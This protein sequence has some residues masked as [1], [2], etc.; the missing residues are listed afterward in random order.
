MTSR[1]SLLALAGLLA[2]CPVTE[3]P[4]DPGQP[5]PDP[6]PTCDDD[7]DGFEA[8]SCGGEDCDDLDPTIHPAAID[9]FGDG[10]DQDCDAADLRLDEVAVP[11][12]TDPHDWR[13]SPDLRQLG[14]AMTI[15]S[16]ATAGHTLN[17]EGGFG[18]P[19][20]SQDR[21]VYGD[22]PPVST[23]P[24]RLWASQGPVDV[25]ATSEAGGSTLEVYAATGVIAVLEGPQG[26]YAGVDGWVGD[27]DVA[28][29]VACGNGELRYLALDLTGEAVLDDVRAVSPADT[30]AVL[31]PAGQ[32]MVLETVSTGAPL[33]RWKIGEDGFTDYLRLA[34]EVA[35]SAFVSASDEGGA[36]FAFVEGERVTAIS[37]SGVAHS[38][39]D[40]QA[41][42]AIGLDVDAQGDAA[43]VWADAA[44]EVYAAAGGFPGDLVSTRIDVEVWPEQVGVG[45]TPGEV[46]VSIW[47]GEDLLLARGVR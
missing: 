11:P 45:L 34:E 35:P 19:L 40:G 30:C 22:L 12:N 14:G 27:D 3:P 26:G 41:I 32:V 28:H 36:L 47:D 16:G 1:L 38:L 46:D 23:R 43:L 42:H 20:T 21:V 33:V 39:G 37:A 44:G 6:D 7:G 18:S 5:D 15:E 2:G 29:V 8:M 9:V 4:A 13:W 24:R 10:V 31:A 25:I 17:F